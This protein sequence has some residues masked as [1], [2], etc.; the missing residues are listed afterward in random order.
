MSWGCI[1]EEVLLIRLQDC[2]KQGQTLS[3][4]LVRSKHLDGT[5]MTESAQSLAKLLCAV[6]AASIGLFINNEDKWAKRWL[7][8]RSTLDNYL[9]TLHWAADFTTSP[10]NTTSFAVEDS[11]RGQVLPSQSPEGW[12]AT[13]PVLTSPL[14][15]LLNIKYL[16]GEWLAHWKVGVCPPLK[17]PLAHMHGTSTRQAA[18]SSE[19]AELLFL[20]QLPHPD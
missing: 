12:A 3:V 7:S 9:I 8:P 1:L 15:G 6:E 4:L 10:G 2:S 16:S 14:F 11:L 13:F 17:P 18:P 20:Q 5:E 19:R